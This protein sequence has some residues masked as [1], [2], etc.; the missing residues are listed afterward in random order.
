MLA[1]AEDDRAAARGR[2]DCSDPVVA[3]ATKVD[4]GKSA[5][6]LFGAAGHDRL[7]SGVRDRGAQARCPDE[8][9]GQDGDGRHGRARSRSLFHCGEVYVASPNMERGRMIGIAL[10]VISACGYGSGPLFAKP[11]YAAGIDWLTLL[12]WRFLFAAIVSWAWLLIWPAQRRALRNVSRRR[13]LVLILLGIFF[14]GNSGTYFAGLEYV[15]ASLSAL[16]VYM[17]PAL[18]AVMTIRFGRKLEGRRAWGALALATAG[19]VLAVGGI[20]PADTPQPIGLVLMI[21]SPIIYA[22]WIVLAGRLAGERGAHDRDEAALG[23]APPHESESTEEARDAAPTAAVM[24]TATAVAWWIWALAVGNPVLPSQ[25]PADAWLPLVGVGIVSTAIALQ[26]FYA[27]ARRIGAAQASLVSTVEPIYTIVLASIL[28]GERLTP[29]QLV[30]GALVIVGV[31]VA[32]SGHLLTRRVRDGGME[33][34]S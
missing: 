20:D 3:T 23:L 5:V 14:V 34:A 28:L 33:T 16:I 1:N 9:V 25:I 32:Q 15:S 2:S 13:I 4:H 12:A 26:T 7:K 22:V 11:A 17:Y 10:V 31:L 8:V 6:D 27:G 24:L 30:G 18:V 19:V 21:S 29:I